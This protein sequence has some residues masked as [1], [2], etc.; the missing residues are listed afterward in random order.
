[1]INNSQPSVSNTAS[2]RHMWITPRWFH[3]WAPRMS[4]VVKITFSSVWKFK[5]LR[6]MMNLWILCEGRVIHVNLSPWAVA[7]M[8]NKGLSKLKSVIYPS[9]FSTCSVGTSLDMGYWRSTIQ[10][11]GCFSPAKLR[12]GNIAFFQILSSTFNHCPLCC[13]ATSIKKFGFGSL[14][15]ILQSGTY[16]AWIPNRSPCN[17]GINL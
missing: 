7:Y 13:G 10:P 1:M 4:S 8:R 12:Q 11:R 5:P 2:G 17:L 14:I 15:V 9:P 16:V 3:T 6:Q